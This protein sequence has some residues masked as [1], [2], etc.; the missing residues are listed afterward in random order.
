[1][2]NLIFFIIGLAV[3]LVELFFLNDLHIISVNINL[4]LIYMVCIALFSEIDK[5]LFLALLMGL[6]K[7]FTV[8][9]I[10]GVNALFFMGRNNKVPST[11]STNTKIGMFVAT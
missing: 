1:M 4:L 7:D 2:R 9:R 8:E 5:A 11:V 6:A 3:I 10:V